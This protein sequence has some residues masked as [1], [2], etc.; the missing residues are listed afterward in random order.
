MF[1]NTKHLCILKL[2]QNSIK[3]NDS[4][5][6][7]NDFNKPLERNDPRL[8]YIDISG[9]QPCSKVFYKDISLTE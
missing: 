1:K 3:K 6:A 7:T 9:S 5:P 2:Y 4:T 8:G